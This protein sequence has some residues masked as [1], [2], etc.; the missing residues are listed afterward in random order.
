MYASCVY[1][2][3]NFHHD[4]VIDSNRKS[5]KLFDKTLNETNAE[6]STAANQPTLCNKPDKQI[7][8]YYLKFLKD[9][10]TRFITD[11]NLN[12]VDGATYIVNLFIVY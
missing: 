4:L 6:Q 9:S 1:E 2:V 7:K 11:L 8:R 3:D 5:H 12:P 10:N